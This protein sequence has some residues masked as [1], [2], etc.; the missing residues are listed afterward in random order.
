MIQ[1]QSYLWRLN[2][3]NSSIN[4]YIKYFKSFVNKHLIDRRN[5]DV[6]PS[7]MNLKSST[8]DNKEKWDVLSEKEVEELKHLVYLGENSTEI[9]EEG[10]VIILSE[11]EKLIGRMFL[12]Q[13]YTVNLPPGCDPNTVPKTTKFVNKKIFSGENCSVCQT[14]ISFILGRLY[15][16]AF[17]LHV[18][19]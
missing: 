14:A 16:G 1:F 4:K 5:Y 6:N 10:D 12:F 3:Q 13:C 17:L 19:Q 18:D 9:K 2:L 11:R 8:E 15:A 7:F